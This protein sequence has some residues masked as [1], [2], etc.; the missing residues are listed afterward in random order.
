MSLTSTLFAGELSISCE[1][2]E[3][4][5]NAYL[6]MEGMNH[7]GNK[8]YYLGYAYKYC[9]R[10]SRHMDKFSIAGQQWLLDTKV[11][12][13]KSSLDYATAGYSCKTIKK[14]GF[15]K[16]VPCYLDSGFCEMPFRDKFAV[17]RVIY[18]SLLSP[19]TLL[20]GFKVMKACYFSSDKSSQKH[21]QL[22][23]EYGIKEDFLR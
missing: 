6:C 5:C 21:Y 14:E 23:K 1:I 9:D 22:L 4:S 11:C 12:L 8:G 16:H 7:C 13:Q 18:D 10:F 15:K 20:P 2:D 17:M 19:N 3:N